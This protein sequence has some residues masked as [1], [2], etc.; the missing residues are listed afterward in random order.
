MEISS[1]KLIPLFTPGSV[2]SG[3][4]SWDDCGR[5][6]PDKLR[7]SS[8][9]DWFPHYAWI[10]VKSARSDFVGSRAYAC[11]GVTC[12]LQFWQNGQGL[13]SKRADGRLNL[14]SHT[15]LTQRSRSGP[16]MPL[17]R[18]GVGT[19]QE[20]SSHATRQGTPSHSRFSSLNHC[21]LILA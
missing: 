18:H 15:P 2:H 21:G 11:L 8:F 12:R 4:A 13:S 5:V 9:P 16:T 19:Y 6:Y 14:N 17:C 7:A 20:K 10:A 3:S 1:C